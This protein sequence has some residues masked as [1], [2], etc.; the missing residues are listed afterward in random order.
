V[1]KTF[2]GEVRG[3]ADP[4]AA[5]R[6][7]RDDKGE[8]GASTRDGLVDEKAGGGLVAGRVEQ[9]VPPLRSP[10]FP[11]ELEGFGALHAPFFA[12]GHIR[13]LFT[14]AWQEIRVRSG[15][16]DTSVSARNK[17]ANAES[18]SPTS[19]RFGPTAS[20]DGRDDTSLAQRRVV[21]ERREIGWVSDL[22]GLGCLG[23]YCFDL[24]VESVAA[25]KVG[26]VLRESGARHHHVTAGL[27][28]LRLQVTL[29]MREET[30]H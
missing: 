17:H 7:G 27:H 8:G 20:R 9:Q 14:S 29:Q 13:G 16:D 6:F 11:V 5:L 3:T 24:C 21:A 2:P 10:G 30:N 25:Q 23:F 1:P 15:R 18:R 28:G 4:S 22:R 12:E 26:Q 19:L